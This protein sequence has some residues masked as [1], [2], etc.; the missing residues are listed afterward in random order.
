MVMC[1]RSSIS[2]CNDLVKGSRM[3]QI[4]RSERPSVLSTKVCVD[5]MM[6]EWV[7]GH[8]DDR[9]D[10]SPFILDFTSFSTTRR[11]NDE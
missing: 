10:R 3:F 11:M 4:V 2:K 9:D 5:C 7:D 8:T 1:S 6:F